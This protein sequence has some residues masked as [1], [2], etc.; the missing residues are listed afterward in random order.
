MVVEVPN[1]L[2]QDSDRVEIFSLFAAA[3]E[4]A[5]ETPK[6]A[7][8]LNEIYFLSRQAQSSNDLILLD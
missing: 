4:M 3:R 1:Q 2:H 5:I 8:A 6:I 7:L